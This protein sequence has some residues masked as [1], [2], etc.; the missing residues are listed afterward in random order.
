MS[1]LTGRAV[2]VTGAA[3]DGVGRGLCEALS[4]VGARVVLCDRDPEALQ[5]AAERYPNAMAIEAD[6]A[7]SAAVERAFGEAVAGAGRIDGLVNNA[8][9]GLSALAHEASEAEVD[10]LHAVDVRGV[11]LMSRQFARHVAARGNAVDRPS[12]DAAAGQGA[13]GI[14]NVSSVHATATMRRY[15]LY[16]GAKAHVE[17][18]TRGMALELGRL[19]VRVNA[20]APGYVHSPQNLALIRTWSDDP[21]RWVRDHTRD[22][23]AL[24]YEIE[25]IDCGRVVTFLLSEAARGITGQTLRVDAGMTAMLYNNDFV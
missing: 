17:G 4:E 11:W 3:G 9:L 21:E 7:D 8:G 23:Q 16:A 14:V 12:R 24:P 6:V 2:L 20:I 25:P 13:A 1:D 15:A 22:Q 5:Q 19:G 10:R 18:L